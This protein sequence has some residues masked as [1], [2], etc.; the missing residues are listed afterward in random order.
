MSSFTRRRRHKSKEPSTRTFTALALN[1][2]SS[3]SLPLFSVGTLATRL[4]RERGLTCG[5]VASSG[6]ELIFSRGVE[7]SQSATDA[8][9]SGIPDGT[10]KS[11]LQSLR[12]YAEMTVARSLDWKRWSQDLD[13]EKVAA[14]FHSIYSDFNKLVAT[15]LRRE[16]SSMIARDRAMALPA[17]EACAAFVKLKE[18]LCRERDLVVS[19]RALDASVVC[20]LPESALAELAEGVREQ[21]CNM[22]PR[23]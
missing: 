22:Q 5:F 16:E 19:M 23:S 20:R 15:L 10:F 18:S 7:E 13:P 17:P 1:Q 4:Q 3:E 9:L 2:P 21:V 6:S 11:R 14:D 8:A 12:K